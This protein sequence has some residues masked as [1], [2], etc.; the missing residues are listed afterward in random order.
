MITAL[1][2]VTQRSGGI[3]TAYI[4]RL[5]ATFRERLD[6]LTRRTRT[7]VRKQATPQAGMYLV[8]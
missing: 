6:I 2:M 5:N 4:K 3:T 8:G 7:S 1:I